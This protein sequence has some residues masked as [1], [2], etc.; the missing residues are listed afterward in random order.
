MATPKKS[1][2]LGNSCSYN[3]NIDVLSW[4]RDFSLLRGDLR[5]E[6][7]GN[8]LQIALEIKRQSLSDKD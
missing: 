2:D 6:T 7:I 5:E 8:Q 3:E 1:F 4:I